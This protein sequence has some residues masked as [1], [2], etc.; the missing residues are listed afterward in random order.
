MSDDT[1]YPDQVLAEA[2]TLLKFEAQFRGCL[3]TAGM[4]EDFYPRVIGDIEFREWLVELVNEKLRGV[5]PV[6]NKKAPSNIDYFSGYC[7]P[8]PMAEQ[9]R[10]LREHF[11]ELASGTYDESALQGTFPDWVE[12][13][14]A[15]PR[16]QLL[17]KTYGKALERVLEVLSTTRN[18][19]FVNYRRGQ[20]GPDRLRQSAK[21]AEALERVA[22]RQEGHNVLVVAGQFG[23]RHRGR[24]VQKVCALMKDSEF[25]MGAFEAAIMLLTHPE[26]L[27]HY[28]DLWVDCAGDGYSW[29]ADGHFENTPYFCFDGGKL[30]FGTYM[31]SLPDD[32]F[33][34]V[35]G[36]S[37]PQ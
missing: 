16:W 34:S 5:E 20:L 25:G 32:S 3:R 36:F 22:N 26:R 1:R 18:G 21:K 10:I 31:V 33:G 35:S 4:S 12:G 15:L 8:K 29:E 11:P 13:P 28:D 14:F 17:A 19:K 24:P 9:A 27:A 2:A 23:I 6:A 7:Q 37:V 30:R